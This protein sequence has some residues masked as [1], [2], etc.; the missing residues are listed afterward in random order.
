MKGSDSIGDGNWITDNLNSALSLWNDKLS[1]IWELLTT[2]PEDFRGGSIFYAMLTINGALKSIAYGLLVLFFVSGV[3]KTTA[4]F[5]EMKRPEAVFKTF[6]RFALTKSAISY[7]NT[8]MNSLFLVIQGILR[9]IMTSSG[10]TLTGESALPEEIAAAIEDVSLLESIP[11][12]AVTLLGTLIIWALSMV[13]ILTVYGR[14]F[15][16]FMATALAPVPLAAFAGEPS[17]SIGRAFIK[18]YA[19][20]CLEGAVILLACV[21][22]TNFAATTPTIDATMAPATIVWNYVG[23]LLFN[24]LILV[25]TVKLSSSLVREFL[26]VG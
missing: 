13:M 4:N 9:T 1:E 22:Y 8:L 18:S 3:M 20:Y 25:S 2:A 17:A 7:C 5:T 12:W 11:L 14:F 16:V 23:G 6:L 21:I 10:I 19:G 15:K 26:G 24:M